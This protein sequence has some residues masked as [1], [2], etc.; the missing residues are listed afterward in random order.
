MFSSIDTDHAVIFVSM[1]WIK[2]E[3]IGK[4]MLRIL[5]R[6]GWYSRRRGQSF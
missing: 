5:P 6:A 3:R 1:E 4:E 2:V